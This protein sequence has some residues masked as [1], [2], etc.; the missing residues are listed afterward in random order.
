MKAV[1]SGSSISQGHA[2]L[3]THTHY[4][5]FNKTFFIPYPESVTPPERMVDVAVKKGLD[6]LC[7][8]DHDEIEGALKA[9]RYVREKELETAVVVGEEVTTADGH[10]L[11]LFLQERIP[12]GLSAVET[13]DLIHGQG[14]LAVAPHPFSYLCPCLGKKIEELSLDGVEVLNA[15]HRDPYVNKLAQQ[16]VGGCFAH[17]GG[18]DAHTSKMLGDAFTE[19]PGKS[20]DE[21]YRAILRKETNPGGGPAPLRHWIFW[22][23]DVAHGVFKKL[24]VPFREGTCSQN[25]PLDRLYQMRCRNKVIAIVGC[26]AFMAS[27]LPF[28]CGMVGEGWI[29]WQ[30]RRKWQEVSSE[31]LTTEE[32]R[33]I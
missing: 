21:L 29:R 5:G 16:E 27:P 17:I 25:D 11:G 7:I 24:I 33:W 14:G 12:P 32:N 20:A 18:S 9:Q 3:H 26:I 22:S 8:T 28:V 15:A 2:D 30:G 19:F 6:V 10:V 23:M 31:W 1:F 4:S 13:I